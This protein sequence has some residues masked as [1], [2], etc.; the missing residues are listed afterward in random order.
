MSRNIKN[1]DDWGYCSDT[2]KLPATLSSVSIPVARLKP[3][4]Y[5]ATAKAGKVTW[6]D[7]KT[8]AYGF[9]IKTEA[10]KGA[11]VTID[12]ITFTG[13]TYGDIMQ[14]VGVKPFS[15][16]IAKTGTGISVKNSIVS[17]TVNTPQNVA[18]SLLNADG[19]EIDR[20]YAGNVSVGTNSVLLPQSMIAGTYIV[21]MNSAQGAVSHKFT[22]VK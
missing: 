5:S 19:K 3:A 12:D 17:Y 8:S 2:I 10:Q 18:I 11:E 16:S 15:A 6:A 14:K 4:P 1:A 9:Q 13:M 21:R 7:C 22:L 20:L